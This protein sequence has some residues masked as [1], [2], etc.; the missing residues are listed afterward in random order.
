MTINTTTGKY[1]DEPW[2]PVVGCRKVSPGCDNCYALDGAWRMAGHQNP[3]ISELYQRVVEVKRGQPAWTGHCYFN[4]S[5]L[6]APLKRKKP[7]VYF[8]SMSDP[9]RR[10]VPDE[11]LDRMFAVM[12]L[13]PQ[14]TFLMCTKR[15]DRMGEFIKIGKPIDESVLAVLG[16]RN[17]PS[18]WAELPW[19][20]PNVWLGVTAENQEMADK[21]IPILLDTPAAVRYVSVEPCLGPVDLTEHLDVWQCPECVLWETHDRYC[22]TCGADRWNYDNILTKGLDLVICGGETGTGARP[23]HP[24]WMRDLRDQCRATEVPFFFKQW[25]NYSPHYD[26]TVG[27]TNVFSGV[28]M[29]DPAPMYKVGKTKAGRLLDGQEHNEMPGMNGESV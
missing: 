29:D 28:P 25:G 1:W 14:H 21:R 15:A 18:S 4:E 7:T 19:P 3:K 8:N 22:C 13:C 17:F 6:L 11:W 27:Y 9:F 26:G 23:M 20:L 12:A 10:V 5:V 2:N 16:H 24:D